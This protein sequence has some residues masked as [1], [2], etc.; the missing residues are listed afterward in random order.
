MTHPEKF[1]PQK[2]LNFMSQA[3]VHGGNIIS[4]MYTNTEAQR[5]EM[6]WR[7][8][9]EKRDG[10]SALS[11]SLQ[12]RFHNIVTDPDR[13]ANILRWTK[14][15][16][17]FLPRFLLDHRMLSVA[18]DFCNS[19]LE[20]RGSPEPEECTHRSLE[21]VLPAGLYLTG[22]WLYQFPSDSVRRLRTI[23]IDGVQ[24]INVPNVSVKTWARY[25]VISNLQRV[26]RLAFDPAPFI[27][28]KIAFECTRDAY[29]IPVSE[30]PDE[31]E[32]G[33]SA[34]DIAKKDD[35]SFREL[36]D[37]ELQR[38][39][40]G[41]A[42]KR[43]QELIAGVGKNPLFMNP[44]RFLVKNTHCPFC[45]DA[46]VPPEDP[47]DV[48]PPANKF[49]VSTFYPSRVTDVKPEYF[50]S[51][52][53][54]CDKCMDTAT[55]FAQ[56]T[57]TLETEVTK[58]TP[59]AP[60]I[61]NTGVNF[62]MESINVAEYPYGC[63]A[64]TP[65][66]VTGDVNALL[67]EQGGEVTVT[68]RADFALALMYWS[69]IEK[70]V[71][72]AAGEYTLKIDANE[73]ASHGD[74][75]T[76]EVASANLKRNILRFSVIGKSFI[77]KKIAVIGK[78]VESDEAHRVMHMIDFN[79][80]KAVSGD[81]ASFTWDE[82]NKIQKFEFRVAH[83]T[84]TVDV[85]I[86]VKHPDRAT[87]DLIFVFKHQ[88]GSATRHPVK[89]P[90]ISTKGKLVYRFKFTQPIDGVDVYYLDTM[91]KVL[92]H[93]M[94]FTMIETETTQATM[95]AADLFR[96]G[97]GMG[98]STGAAKEAAMIVGQMKFNFK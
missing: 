39:H 70:V 30:S 15:K 1:I 6:I 50:P 58:V 10:R 11:I 62:D 93:N 28:G 87:N 33:K 36:S 42:V 78:P 54:V 57:K 13:H 3:F 98:K 59:V 94:T 32:F 55:E 90:R 48:P 64:S 66:N 68:D 8:A 76:F 26:I 52:V 60:K 71:V 74:V 72:E 61:G 21:V 4:L 49:Y 92:T 82:V 35:V 40:S 73:M 12:R 2:V 80:E 5:A 25:P 47:D 85:Q 81:K 19:V 67:T 79:P 24:K 41:I 46:I 43:S 51:S 84:P 75:T 95:Q 63:F 16:H 83:K 96:K 17:R 45:G 31:S 27:I 20:L 22:I 14:N 69:H 53:K 7:Y 91:L 18:S 56:V 29:Q 44:N 37:L 86:Y 23:E 77:I 38:I 89:I 34:S 88:D 65:K 9:T 97:L